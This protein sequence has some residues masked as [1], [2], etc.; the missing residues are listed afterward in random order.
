MLLTAAS[1][2][3]T[4]TR[5][6]PV[7]GAN[8]GAGLALLLI[9]GLGLPWSLLDLMGVLPNWRQPAET[10]FLVTCALLN[11]LLHGALSLFLMRR[12]RID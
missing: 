6:G 1:A 11:V 12:R 8:I 9:G 5:S 4:L 7:G 10:S 2:F 3:L